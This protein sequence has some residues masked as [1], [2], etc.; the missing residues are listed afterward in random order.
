MKKS[1]FIEDE[2]SKIK[3]DYLGNIFYDQDIEDALGNGEKLL[4]TNFIKD[5]EKS[6]KNSSI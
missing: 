5:L 2:L 4:K 3:I 6:I 1:S